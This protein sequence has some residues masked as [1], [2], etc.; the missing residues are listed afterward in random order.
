MPL[1]LVQLSNLW[2]LGKKKLIHKLTSDV[3]STNFVR[4]ANF[5]RAPKTVTP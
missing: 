1:N 2:G 3:I 4:W 5:L